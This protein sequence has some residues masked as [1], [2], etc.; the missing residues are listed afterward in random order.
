MN[1]FSIGRIGEMRRIAARDH[2]AQRSD[3]KIYECFRLVHFRTTAET[4]S[5]AL[6]LRI[7]RFSVRSPHSSSA[8]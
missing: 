5:D 6:D 8:V 1:D 7:V 4:M 3:E 2:R